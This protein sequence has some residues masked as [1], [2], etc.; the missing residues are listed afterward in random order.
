M[1]GIIKMGRRNEFKVA[2]SFTICM[3]EIAWLAE[4]CERT[5]QKASVVVNKLLREA[6]VKDKTDPN[7]QTSGASCDKCDAWTPHTVDMICTKCNKLNEKLKEKIES[8]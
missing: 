5:K 3:A 8:Q 2:K 1:E 4:Y 7:R 6:M